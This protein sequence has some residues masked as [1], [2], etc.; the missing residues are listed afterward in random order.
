MVKLGKYKY[1]ISAFAVTVVMSSAFCASYAKWVGYDSS[2]AAHASAGQWQNGGEGPSVPSTGMGY[3]GADGKYHALDTDFGFAGYSALFYVVPSVASQ[4][5]YFSLNGVDYGELAYNDSTGTVQ[6]DGNAF[7]INVGGGV[8]E[9]CVSMYQFPDGGG[10]IMFD[11]WNGAH[12][13]NEE[14]DKIY[15]L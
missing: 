15:R 1:I 4:K 13:E 10:I 8:K 5:I 6:K 12:D 2:V 11:L 3:Y 14:N 9:Y 7:V